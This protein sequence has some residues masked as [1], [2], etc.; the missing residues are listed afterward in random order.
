MTAKGEENR[1]VKK[2]KGRRERA[3]S[4]GE[5]DDDEGRGQAGDIDSKYISSELAESNVSKNEL[6]VPMQMRQNG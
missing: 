1:Q 3:S 4:G 5:T 6:T 2:G